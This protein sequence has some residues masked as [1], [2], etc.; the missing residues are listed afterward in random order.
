[1]NAIVGREVYDFPDTV[2]LQIDFRVV[3]VQPV[4]EVFQRILT[5]LLTLLVFP[6][7]NPSPG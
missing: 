2:F 3:V 7:H 4:G 1:M 5:V 6:T